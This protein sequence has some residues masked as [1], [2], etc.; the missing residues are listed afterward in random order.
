M[1]DTVKKMMLFLILATVLGGCSG[2]ISEQSDKSEKTVQNQLQTNGSDSFQDH[3]S[4]GDIIVPMISARIESEKEWD[5]F[6]SLQGLSEDDFFKATRTD[7]VF[8]L[9]T[10]FRY[11]DYQEMIG[12]LTKRSVI[13]Q[14]LG[15]ELICVTIIPG[16]NT[17]SWYFYYNDY[18]CSIIIDSACRSLADVVRESMGDY[19]YELKE[20]KSDT[21]EQLV[22]CHLESTE[23]TK[24]REYFFGK[25]GNQSIIFVVCNASK[26]KSEVI[27]NGISFKP[28]SEN[29]NPFR[30]TLTDASSF[31]I[32]I[33]LLRE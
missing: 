24:N 6:L 17:V 11:S 2:Q 26:E 15:S 28:F 25:N 33:P 9:Q 27:V 31:A 7:G 22:Y 4:G 16:T 32:I 29:D 14:G 13:P 20:C 18:L 30:Q 5:L 8:F 21:L 10:E 3:S 23:L 1:K 19:R 12:L